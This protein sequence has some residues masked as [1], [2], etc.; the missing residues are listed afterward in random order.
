MNKFRV[1]LAIF[2]LSCAH[3]ALAEI[4]AKL[5]G[6]WTSAGVVWEFTQ[7]TIATQHVDSSGKAVKPVNKADISYQKV[8][9]VWAIKFKKPD[10]SPGGSLL[11]VFKDENT[12][13]I[14]S[15]GQLA[16]ILKRVPQ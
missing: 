13:V 9:D 6:K 8:G 7:D 3:F 16:L 11:A 15:P 1:L 5:L 12:A 2:L 4:P 10:G 14:D